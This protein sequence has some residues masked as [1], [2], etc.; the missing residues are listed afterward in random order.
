[1]RIGPLHDPLTWYKVTYTGEQVAR[2]DF[3]NKDRSRWTGTNC[4]VLEVTLRNLVNSIFDFVPC[5]R[6]MQRAYLRW[7]EA[8]LVL[9]DLTD[10]F[11]FLKVRL[12][13]QSLHTSP[14]SAFSRTCNNSW[15]EPGSG[16]E[17]VYWLGRG[18]NSSTFRLNLEELLRSSFIWRWFV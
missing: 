18:K 14:F 9:K 4:I 5:Q 12:L 15:K 13:T 11:S 8:T 2:W 1:M 7:Y 6:I 16:A 17:R 10:C 3:Q